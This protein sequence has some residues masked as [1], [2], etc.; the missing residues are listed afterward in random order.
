MTLLGLGGATS[1]VVNEGIE[2]LSERHR[3]VSC[4][5]KSPKRIPLE[6]IKK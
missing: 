4:L 2:G 6:K 5:G 1:E 3:Y